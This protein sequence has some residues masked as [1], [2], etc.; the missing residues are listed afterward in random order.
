MNIKLFELTDGVGELRC[1]ARVHAAV[2]LLY[3]A[4]GEYR[5]EIGRSRL[6]HG[7]LFL[8]LEDDVPTALVPDH[9]GGG[10]LSVEL[11][12]THGR[13]C[14]T[15]R[16]DYRRGACLRTVHKSVIIREL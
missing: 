3:I 15:F 6:R 1:P 7:V 12:I 9:R 13:E 2:F 4:D 14:V 8:V 5:L 16:C 11:H 10:D